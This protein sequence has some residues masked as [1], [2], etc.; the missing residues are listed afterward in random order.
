M[1]L[2][3]KSSFW[4]FKLISFCSVWL[5]N[6][7]RFLPGAPAAQT[8]EGWGSYVSPVLILSTLSRALA[9]PPPQSV[10]LAVPEGP[11]FQAFLIPTV[12]SL[13]QAGRSPTS[14]C[15][16]HNCLWPIMQVG[17]AAGGG[18]DPDLRGP[19]IIYCLWLHELIWALPSPGETASSPFFLKSWVNSILHF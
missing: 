13:G 9:C 3:S 5:G 16:N 14:I 12:E 2:L 1:L 6:D 7:C 8:E 15:M 17:V 11:Y 18:Q 10:D 4:C 19:W